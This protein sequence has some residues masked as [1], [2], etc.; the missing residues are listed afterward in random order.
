MNTHD[1]ADGTDPPAAASAGSM[2]TTTSMAGTQHGGGT[3][4]SGDGEQV[5][6]PYVD[7]EVPVGGPDVPA[8]QCRPTTVTVMALPEGH[9]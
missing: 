7:G 5:A 3:R 2:H 4:L 8:S 9:E 1:P 6:G